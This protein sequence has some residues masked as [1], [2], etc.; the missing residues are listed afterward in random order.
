[1]SASAGASQS[2]ATRGWTW[3]M[4]PARRRRP[5]RDGIRERPGPDPAVVAGSGLT[6]VL[7]V[8]GAVCLQPPFSAVFCRPSRVALGEPVMAPPRFCCT[9][10]LTLSHVGSSV[11]VSFA[12][13][14]VSR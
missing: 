12:L 5:A 13:G 2:S 11:G 3:P 9:A 7:S 14:S 4:R 1:M 8:I 10:S 6:V